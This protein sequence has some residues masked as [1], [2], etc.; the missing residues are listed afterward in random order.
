MRKRNFVIRTIRNG[1]VQIDG[2]AF[3]PSTRWLQYD[4]RLDG[5]RFAFGLYWSGDRME[6]FVYQWGTEDAYRAVG[7]LTTDEIAIV[8]FTGEAMAEN[9][10]PG[11]DCVDGYW[12]WAF[13]YIDGAE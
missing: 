13:W 11:P 5:M 6:P 4:G 8:R 7:E 12:P 2:Q 1:T 3:R 9:Y 10:W